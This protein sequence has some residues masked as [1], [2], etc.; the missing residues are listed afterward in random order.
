MSVAD[1]GRT[2]SDDH[3]AYYRIFEDVRVGRSHLIKL[4]TET[5][6]YRTKADATAAYR[7]LGTA[8]GRATYAHELVETIAEETGL[9]VTG[10]QTEALQRPGKGYEGVVVTFE[11]RDGSY[12]F[13]TVA[14][15]SGT[16][17]ASVTGFCHTV[18]IHPDDL[19]PLAERARAR[20]V[21]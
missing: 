6:L 12:R 7:A 14:T 16:M 13:V 19:K 8:Q 2:S 5:R 10:I 21:A 9:T 4:R 20:L 15:Q 3:L 17:V 11:S 18:A 1:E